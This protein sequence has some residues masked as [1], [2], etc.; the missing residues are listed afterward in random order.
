VLPGLVQA[1]GWV[2]LLPVVLAWWVW[3]LA[4]PGKPGA[5]RSV[6]VAVLLL[7]VG[8]WATVLLAGGAGN[9]SG[10][11]V[12]AVP[13]VTPTSEAPSPTE[14]DDASA[15]PSRSPSEPAA[16]ASS[17]SASPP[18]SAAAS[19]SAA[20]AG[21]ESS[22]A[23]TSAEPET[24]GVPSGAQRARVTDVVDGDTIDVRATGAGPLA[25]GSVVTVRLLEVDTPETKHPT[26][27][28]ECF[29]PQASSYVRSQLSG[30]RVWLQSDVED[31]G[32]YGRY[33]RYVWLADGTH[34]N[35]RLVSGGYAVASLYQ[36]NDRHIAA[37]RAAQSQ[38][39][40]A[41]R[42]LWGACG[43]ADTPAEPPQQPPPAPPD[44]PEADTPAGAGL[45]RA[46][47]GG[48]DKDCSDFSS[49]LR[50]GPADYHGL[51]RDSDGI[52]C[53]NN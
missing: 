32:R 43:G 20:P 36:P 47:T 39:K 22:P 16:A 37:I 49:P 24:S 46:P 33:L 8:L 23:E 13:S 34:F 7:G 19:P 26:V 45:P 35:Q 41:D 17:P 12:A 6:A 1:A 11:Q 42:G 3:V 18:A 9:A 29:G 4:P 40:A 15:E 10:G 38:A 31:Q 48:A 51:D 50:V 25:V 30:Q 53:E 5:Q 14:A 28:T 27:P 2:V 44:E 21:V 52:G